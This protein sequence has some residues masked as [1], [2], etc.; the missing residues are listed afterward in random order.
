MQQA[1]ASKQ[2]DWNQYHSTD[3]N[4]RPSSLGL[5][6]ATHSRTMDLANLPDR[7]P[8]EVKVANINY[9]STD[10]DLFYFFGG[11]GNVSH[12]LFKLILCLVFQI[13]NPKIV[14]RE[15]L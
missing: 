8:F 6:R 14:R 13:T 11:E 3:G 1:S 5:D 4:M 10:N 2:G 9:K 7:P 12:Q 15:I